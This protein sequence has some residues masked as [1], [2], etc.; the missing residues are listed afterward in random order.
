MMITPSVD[1]ATVRKARRAA[2]RLGSSLNQL[3]RHYLG[4]LA[5]DA[6]P[7]DELAELRELSGRS[8]GHFRGWRFDRDEL[9]ERR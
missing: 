1:E 4:E 3:V 7:E 9:Q 5:G 2:A 8:G 6:S